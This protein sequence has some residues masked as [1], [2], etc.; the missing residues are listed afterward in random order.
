MAL[1]DPPVA[2]KRKVIPTEKAS[3][4]PKKKPKTTTKES[5]K[6][7][8]KKVTVVSEEEDDAQHS[9]NGV[10]II[11]MEDVDGNVTVK[12]VSAP[13]GPDNGEEDDDT[14]LERMKRKWRSPIYG[15]FQPEVKVDYRH[16]RKRHTFVC[17]AKGCGHKTHRYLDTT[18]AQST[19]NMR[20]HAVTCWGKETV[21]KADEAGD[22][23]VVRTNIVQG[24]LRDGKITAA[25]ERKGK[26]K[27]TF[28]HRQH[29]KIET[30]A[31][32]V[33][34]VTE[35]LRPF[36]I[37]S[38]RGFQCLMKTG[39]PGYYLPSPTTVSRDVKLVFARARKRMA[40]MLQE[41]DGDLN[42]ATDAWTSPNHR[43]FVAITVHLEMDGEPI[44]ILLDLVE[45]SEVCNLGFN[46]AA[47]FA[48]VLDDFGIQNKILSITCDNAS[49]NDTMIEE[50]ADLVLKYKGE[51]NRV[52]C[53]A[54]IINLVAK[55]LLKQFDVPKGK[56]HD[57]M[58]T[59][60]KELADLAVDLDME[61][62]QTRLEAGRS[63]Q[64]ENDDDDIQGWIDELD[65]MSEGEKA[66]HREEVQPVSLVLVKLRKL[67]YKILH[68][69]TILLPAWKKVLAALHLKERVMPRDVTTRWNSTFDML[70]FAIEYRS[71]VQTMTQQHEEALGMYE[72]ANSDWKIAEQLR[73]VLRILKDATLFFS[74]E[75]PNLATVI[76]A[77]DH[78]DEK[79]GSDALN[80]KLH[81]AIRASVAVAKRTCN[82]Y[83]S[84][85][86]GSE[87][88]RIAMVLHP[89]YK[90]SYFEKAE[91]DLEWQEKARQLVRQVY[92]TR[93]AGL[94]V[95]PPTSG[96]SE[97]SQTQHSSAAPK[98]TDN[99]FDSLPALSAPIAR[100]HRDELE[101]YLSTDPEMTT[102]VIQW[103]VERR[104]MY[105]RLSRMAIDYLTIPATSV[106]VE[107]VFS[108]G[109]LL[110]SSIRNRLS[111]Q[112]TR[113]ILCLG[114][115][116]LIGMIKDKDLTKIAQMP[117][118]E[119]VGDDS[120]GEF[121]PGLG[122][123][124]IGVD[125]LV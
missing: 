123:D 16:G 105:P 22:V 2:A 57:A 4:I 54:H 50:I 1:D 82:R 40:K 88:Y 17:A 43:A 113:A 49:A 81:S 71:A 107:R 52:R 116:S 73:D 67:S 96:L 104:S 78:I 63:G 115:W 37:V 26:G 11:E 91:W 76:P 103:W 86:D 97:S 66:A 110:I 38:D 84:R 20:K 114:Q 60:E 45:V 36:K 3:G 10:E 21:E 15:F 92:E 87:L 109:R 56:K 12:K 30:K 85:T 72:M 53:F 61:D 94:E 93:Y 100:E 121:D 99:I 18:D 59:A 28:S 32:I 70:D 111:S 124:K 106:A 108:Q 48:Q 90:L 24:I 55:S 112:S 83:Y 39:R 75:T 7:P 5:T 51:E 13:T 120:E 125:E 25:F 102:N 35:S 58:S 47:A 33:R 122:W 23:D 8:T 29:T 101:R 98:R 6:R 68:S 62:L 27:V 118:V 79:F 117:D 95:P 80:P 69:T 46:L 14:E 19:G 42:F 119:G 64:A 34:W 77:M 31:E 65:S 44:S 89:R 41:Y 74:R 9:D